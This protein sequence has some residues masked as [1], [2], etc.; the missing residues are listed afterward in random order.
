MVWQSV[1]AVGNGSL[2]NKLIELVIG[3]LVVGMVLSA[4]QSALCQ[5]MPLIVIALAVTGVIW[6]VVAIVRNRR[7]RW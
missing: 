1:M 2:F 6:L 3:L 7:N 4:L 5:L